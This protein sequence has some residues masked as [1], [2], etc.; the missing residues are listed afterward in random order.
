LLRAGKSAQV[1]K[2]APKKFG[3]IKIG[4]I[5]LFFGNAFDPNC[6]PVLFPG[7]ALTFEAGDPNEQ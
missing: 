5:Y 6:E 1:F 2:K 4:D 7:E 3:N